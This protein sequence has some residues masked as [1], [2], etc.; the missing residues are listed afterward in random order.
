MNRNVAIVYDD[1]RKPGR[2]IAAITGN[3]SFGRT[4]YKRQTLMERIRDAFSSIP[5]VTGFYEA[6]SAESS[7]LKDTHV[8]LFFSDFGIAKIKDLETIVYKAGYAHENYKI[9]QANR[10]AC[11]IF[12]DELEF[13]KASRNDLE[14]YTEIESDVFTDLGDVNNF[15]SFI[16]GGFDARFFN[17]LTGDDHTVVKLSEKKSK[18]KA[19][20]TFYSLLPDDMKQ[21]FVRPFDYFEDEKKAGYRMQRY[22]MTD[23]AIRYV[24]G[25]IGAEEFRDILAQLFYFLAHRMTKEVTEAEYEAE[26][27]RLYIDKVKERTAQLKETEGYEELARTIAANTPYRDIDEI[28]SR[29]EKLY[30][31]IHSGRSF[32]H[33][34]AV[35][36]GDMCFSNILYSGS[37]DL[38]IL[39]D[40]KGAMTTDELYMDPFYDLAKLSHSICGYYDYFNSGLYEICLDANM[41]ASLRV[42]ADN[43]QY[44]EMFRES[45]EEAGIDLAL[46]RLYEASLFLSMLPLHMDRP[47]KVFGFVLNALAILNS[48][49]R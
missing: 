29:Y 5:G 21:W 14:G 31:S 28:V 9:T 6:G 13:Y 17:S 22:H 26:A 20:Y 16:T 27:K 3:N 32:D 33:V 23:L 19:E 15:R 4:I 11:V 43:R 25:S 44:V 36:H 34:K 24:H 41:K 49:E 39:I 2:Q 35:S 10:I 40:P 8:I 18:I 12:K 1:T 7:H 48:L 38:V 42:D 37:A 47:Q 46:V 30:E 45:L